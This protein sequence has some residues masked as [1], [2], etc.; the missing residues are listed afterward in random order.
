MGKRILC[1][2]CYQHFDN[3]EIEVECE[4]NGLNSHGDLV[5]EKRLNEK[6]SN[7]WGNDLESHRVFKPKLG[8]FSFLFPYKPKPESCPTCGYLSQRFICPNCNNWLPKEMVEKGAEIISVIGGP[9]SGKTNYIVTLIQQMKKYGNKLSLSIIPQQVG[10]KKEEFTSYKY[11]KARE[12]IFDMKMPVPKTAVTKHEIPWI[13][14]L[15]SVETGKAV[16]LVFYDTAGENFKDSDSIRKNAQYLRESKAVICVLDTLSIKRIQKVLESNDIDNN[17]VATPFDETLTALFNFQTGD[18]NLSDKPFAFV[19][20]K[21]DVVI[22]HH[23]DLGCDVSM[24]LNEDGSP[25]NSDFIK[26]GQLNLAQIEQAHKAIKSYMDDAEIWDASE[27]SFNIVS[28]WGDNAR[29]FG[30][31]SFG[32][33]PDENATLQGDVEGVIQPYRVMDPLVWVLYKVGG[34][35]KK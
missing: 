19:M 26:T 5:C 35:F 21:F 7:H 32:C 4:N 27:H 2:Y 12:I 3:N 30:V 25:R 10:R 23:E 20:S 34:F 33:M 22:D 31:S 16:Y 17:D 18:K 15:E 9:A 13:L 14:R 6:L 24:F 11:E 1:P 28:K 8:L 29:F